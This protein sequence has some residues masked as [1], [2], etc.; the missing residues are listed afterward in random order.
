M[1][2]PVLAPGRHRAPGHDQHDRPGLG[3]QRGVGARRRRRHVRGVPGVVRHAV[4]RVLPAAAADP[5][6]ADRARPGV[7]VPR[8]SGDEAHW[9][10]RWDLAIIVGSFVP[11]VLWG[12]AFANIVRGVPIDADKEYTG[13]SV[14]L[15][16][17]FG[18][19]GGLVTLL[20]FLTHGAM[21]VALKTDGEIRHRGPG[22]GGPARAR[23]RGG[24]GASSWSGRRSRPATLGSAVLFV[25]AAARSGRGLRRGRSGREGWALRRHVRRASRSPWR[26]C[27]SRCSP[28]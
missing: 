17:P 8:T 19:L 14:D 11:A 28:T 2:L 23:R 16:N 24:R 1:L 21:F 26:G 7:R 15:L 12:V 10:R 9:H 22:A 5:G 18:L 3:R 20:L 25:L 27:S 13:S 4:Q 6:R